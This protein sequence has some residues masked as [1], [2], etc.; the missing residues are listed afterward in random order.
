[1]QPK[2]AGLLINTGFANVL[3][4]K[5]KM[6]FKFVDCK[7]NTQFCTVYLTAESLHGVKWT[8]K[9]MKNILAKKQKNVKFEMRIH[10]LIKFWKGRK[11]EC[12]QGKRNWNEKLQKKQ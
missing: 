6:W 12:I 3:L 1:M 2:H 9:Q 5:P 10:L 7:L 8:N 4:S 11:T